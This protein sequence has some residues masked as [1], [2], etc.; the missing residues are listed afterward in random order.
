MKTIIA[1]LLFSLVVSEASATLLAGRASNFMGCNADQKKKIKVAAKASNR[2]VTGANKYLATLST[3][4]PGIFRD[5]FGP[6]EEVKKRMV[7]AHFHV[8]EDKA[9]LQKYDCATCQTEHPNDYHT[10]SAYANTNGI[11]LCGKFWKGDV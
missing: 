5:H 8:I 4:K 6:Y 11:M 9:T 7:K 1:A 3:E 2:L 10:K